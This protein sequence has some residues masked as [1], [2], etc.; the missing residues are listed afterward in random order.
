MAIVNP[1]DQPTRDPDYLRYSKPIGDIPA[2]TSTAIAINTAAS[3]LDTAVSGIDTSIKEG[4]K[5]KAYDQIDPLRDQFTQ[6]LEKIK[7]NLDQGIIP[8]PVQAVVGS[9]TGKTSLLDANASMDEPDL[10]PG[11]SSG[12][13]RIQQ[14]ADAK[15]AGSPRLNDTQYAKDTLSVAKQLRNQYGVGYRDYIDQEV[16]KVSGLPVANSYYQNM[17][18]DINR[19]LTQIG[20]TKDDIGTLMLKNLDVP[21]D[22][23]K[24]VPGMAQMI[25][26]RNAGDK[27]ITDGMVLESIGDWQHLQSQIKIDAAN[28]AS[29][30]DK[31]SQGQID[32]SSRLTRD[33][34]ETV[35]LYTKNIANLSGMPGLGETMKYFQDVQAGL[36]PEAT[37]QEVRQ[38]VYQLQAYRQGIY[39]QLKARS[40]DSDPIIGGDKSEAILN[41]ALAPLD[42]IIKLANDKDA[43]PAFFHMHQIQAVKDDD[44]HNML[45]SKDL[46]AL[47]RQMITA[48]GVW[49][50][51]YFPEWIKDISTNPELWGPIKD[52]FAQEALS[53]VVPMTDV[54]G[55]PIPRVM[56]DAIVEGKEKAVPPEFH[57]SVIGTVSDLANPNMPADAKDS[58]IKW[59]FGP[60]NENVLNELKM[61]YRDPR[62]GEMVPGKYR[63]FNILSAPKITNSVAETAKIHPENYEMYEGTLQKEFGNLYR[64]DV[65]TLNK[66]LEKPYL[67]VHFSFNDKTNSYG[68]VDNQNRPV[69]RMERALGN[70]FPDKVYLNSMLDVLDRVNSG[71][72]NLAYVHEKNPAGAQDTPKYLLQTLQTIGFRP[73]DNISGA[74]QGMLKAVI[75][76]QAPDMTPEELNN[77]VLK[78]G[79]DSQKQGPSVAQFVS[80]PTNEP[81]PKVRRGIQGNLSDEK[82]MGIQTDDI[83][84]GM[85]ARDF[86][87]QLQGRK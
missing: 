87:K 42:T 83:P 28:R 26:R 82:L 4:I 31:T 9:S 43:S 86:I 53:S 21:G 29:R 77:R 1:Q 30:D 50:E 32:E 17:L 16:S 72:H 20:K 18:Q 46:G 19:Q 69:Q 12:L 75:K 36:H 66:M 7:S 55:Q 37:D 48:R 65:V 76:S 44:L 25:Q 8:A 62:T 78:F 64:S 85:S 71:I 41:N 47:S 60:G 70:Q 39:S 3:G 59:A 35:R 38:R 10:P 11:L 5:T 23:S 58:K 15:A 61:D 57:G 84:E 51:Q 22:P 13:D 80:N 54:R 24:G 27:T 73:G 45:V 67:G 40:A 79:Q 56:K 52:R 34:A 68:L 63:A 49:G 74:T 33:A 2:N 14:L 81:L 6:G